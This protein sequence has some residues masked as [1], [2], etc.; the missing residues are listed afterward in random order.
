M[1]VKKESL[2][3]RISKTDKQVLNRAATLTGVNLTS[4]V[5][6][7][8]MKNAREALDHEKRIE[9]SKRDLKKLL[10]ILESN[11]PDKNLSNAFNYYNET[12]D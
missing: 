11:E 2:N 1:Q 8:A 10:E 7:S 5:I 4:F 6:Q 9:L 12:I 3:M